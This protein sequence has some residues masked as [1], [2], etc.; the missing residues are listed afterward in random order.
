[1]AGRRTRLLSRRSSGCAIDTFAATAQAT[2]SANAA[3]PHSLSRPLEERGPPARAAIA[4]PASVRHLRKGTGRRRRRRR[5]RVE[6]RSHDAR[7]KSKERKR[8]KRE[9]EG[10]RHCL[11]FLLSLLY[12]QW[13][14]RGG[15]GEADFSADAFSPTKVQSLFQHV[16]FSVLKVIFINIFLHMSSNIFVPKQFESKDLVL[17]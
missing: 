13:R 5:R 7:R 1:M 9:G 3:A 15:G 8:K 17:F 12:D 10:R 2:S 11:T 6:T 16:E 4:P 14:R